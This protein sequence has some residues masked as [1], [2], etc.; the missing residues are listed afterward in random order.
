MRTNPI[1]FDFSRGRSGYSR[2][3]KRSLPD[4][5]LIPDEALELMLRAAEM[6]EEEQ[7]VRRRICELSANDTSDNSD[8]ETNVSK[9]ALCRMAI[10][11]VCHEVMLDSKDHSLLQGFTSRPFQRE[12]QQRRARV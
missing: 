2:Y 12:W 11:L 5:E 3:G 6:D 1:D 8:K 9:Q 10:S 4:A 7:C